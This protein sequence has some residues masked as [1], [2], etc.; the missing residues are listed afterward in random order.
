[1]TDLLSKARSGRAAALDYLAASRGRHSVTRMDSA[2][3]GLAFVNF[4]SRRVTDLEI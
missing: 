4:K 3:E 1:M 2:A